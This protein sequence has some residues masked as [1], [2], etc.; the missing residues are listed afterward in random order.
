[1]I[2]YLLAKLLW[3]VRHSGVP[4]MPGHSQSQ[5]MTLLSGIVRL[6]LSP[7]LQPIPFSSVLGGLVT[8]FKPKD[9]HIYAKEGVLIVALC[10]ILWS[11]LVLFLLSLL[12]QISNIIDAFSKLV[13]VLRLQG[14]HFKW[15]LRPQSFP[16]FWRSF[17][18]LIGGMGCWSLP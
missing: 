8:L 12:G 10:W 18:H 4:I 16:L 1:M 2:R 3:P 11:S 14:N 9:F 15:R 7:Y 17:T 5:R 13:L 6:S